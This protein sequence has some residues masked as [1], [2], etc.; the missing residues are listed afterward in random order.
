VPEAVREGRVIV[1]AQA[2][3]WGLARETVSAAVQ[4]AS[5]LLTNAVHATPYLGITLRMGLADDGLCVEVWDSSPVWSRPSAPDMSVPRGPVADDAPD[6][7]GWGLGIVDSLSER[8]GVR[9]E[10]EGKCVWAV[11]KA[12]FR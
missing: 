9:D 3:Q 2:L 10:F 4:V 1:E 8:R 7:G 6:P 11:I 5:E 12:K